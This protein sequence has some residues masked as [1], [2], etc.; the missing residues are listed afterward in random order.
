[1]PQTEKPSNFFG[2]GSHRHGRRRAYGIVMGE[3]SVLTGMMLQSD[4][5]VSRETIWYD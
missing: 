2:T 3:R 1:M 4:K 5:S